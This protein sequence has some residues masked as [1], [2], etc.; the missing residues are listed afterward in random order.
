MSTQDIQPVPPPAA[1]DAWL[2][3]PPP[4]ASQPGGY[5]PQYAPDPA[6]G[7]SIASM[8]TGIVGVLFFFF[9][10]AL[11]AVIMGHIAQKKE[12]RAKGFWITG[13]ITGYVGL[14]V[15]IIVVLAAIAIPVYIGVQNN[16]KDSATQSNLMNAK[17]AVVAYY[18][19]NGTFPSAINA[20]NLSIYGYSGTAVSDDSAAAAAITAFCLKETSAST[21]VFYVTESSELTKVKPA[22]CT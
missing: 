14:V 9:P 5:P 15:G 3:S 19:D 17:V 7:L 10:A 11:A 22:G 8:V 6:Q 2:N 18:T 13:L 4:S 21:T 20:A 12:P 1:N 16:A